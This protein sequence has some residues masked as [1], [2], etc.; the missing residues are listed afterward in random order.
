MA[1]ERQSIHG[2]WKGRLA[3]FLA[4]T[5]SAVGLGS[6]WK[7][8]YITG[9][10]GGGA[11]V[12]VYLACVYFVGVPVMM[13][14]V[15]MGRRA[16]QNPVTAVGTLAREAGATTKWMG[17]GLLGVATSFVILSY[18]VNITGWAFAYIFHAGS[19]AFVGA[20]PEDVAGD[21][22]SLLENWPALIGWSTLMLA[23]TGA[24]VMGGVQ[25][26]I[27]RAVTILMPGLLVILLL[28]VGYCMAEGAFAE[29]VR[30]M[31]AP[32]FDKLTASGVL[33]ALGHAFFTLSLASGVMVAYGAYVPSDTSIFK[34]AVAVVTADTVVSLLSGLAIFPL[35]FQYGLEPGE[36][37]PLIFMTL[38]IAF[39]EMPAGTI[40]GTLFFVMLFVA[41]FGSAIS[42]LEPT[43]ATLVE[44]LKIDRARA[45][46]LS[47]AVAWVLSIPS[48]LSF[49]VIAGVHPA[50]ALPGFEDK[51]IF[52]LI[53]Y[54]T[55]NILLPISGLLIAIFC[56]WVMKKESTRDELRIGRGT[57]YT[58]WLF[59]MRFVVPASIVVIFVNIVWQTF[60]VTD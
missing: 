12:I 51:T 60:F 52:D 29:G 42:L 10:N 36:G 26:G 25:K 46:L 59:L 20:T 27:E 3:F 1:E 14:E 50:K 58:A 7:F 13:A 24:T 37:P 23:L 55:A 22:G 57:I 45:V 35:V 19:G 2:F 8:P 40:F 44:Q 16:R 48:I 6:I 38:P 47:L 34:T 21:F 17:M 11:F 5:G 43:V 39:G 30:F 15:L 49:N 9:E 4:A 54:V 33:V 18:Y 32:E 28:L 56:A 53:D 41:A 31:F